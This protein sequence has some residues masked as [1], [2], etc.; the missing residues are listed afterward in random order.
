[1]R[2]DELESLIRREMRRGSLLVSNRFPVPGVRP[3][4]VIGAGGPAGTPLYV[5]RM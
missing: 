2:A 4:K 3:W 5:W 1:M